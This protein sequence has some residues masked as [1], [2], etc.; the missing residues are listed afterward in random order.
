MNEVVYEQE[1]SPT[2]PPNQPTT[3][4][5]RSPIADLL[6]LARSP[7]PGGGPELRQSATRP[8]SPFADMSVGLVP[9]ASDTP[10]AT[11]PLVGIGVVAIS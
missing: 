7:H 2:G 8:L 6:S 3:P 11:G 1:A 10:R 9:P 5:S 4:R